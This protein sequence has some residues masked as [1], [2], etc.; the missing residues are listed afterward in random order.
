MRCAILASRN[1]G[2]AGVGAAIIIDLVTIIAGFTLIKSTV[3][4]A[5]EAALRI[6][7]VT[8]LVVP[9]IAFFDA[10]AHEGVAAAGVLA[11]AETGV[12]FDKVAVIA[13]FN[14]WIDCSI[15]ADRMSTGWWLPEGDTCD[16]HDNNERT[17]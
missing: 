4:T 1:R 12:L 15:A 11:R 2:D 6:T 17:E 13:L 16:D 10:C 9:V 8:G 14:A 3:T 5:F 7:A